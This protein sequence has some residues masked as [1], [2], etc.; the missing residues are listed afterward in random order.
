MGFVIERVENIVGEK[1][2]ENASCHIFSFS[3]NALIFWSC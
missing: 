1:K 2:A 3:N